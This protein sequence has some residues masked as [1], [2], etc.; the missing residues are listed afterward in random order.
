MEYKE[1]VI[2]EF[3]NEKGQRQAHTRRQDGKHMSVDGASVPVFTTAH[4]DTENE[5]VRVAEEAID[6]RKVSLARD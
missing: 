4:S 6:T 1:Y 5:V 2:T 3:V